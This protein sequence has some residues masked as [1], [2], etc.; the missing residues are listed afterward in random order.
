[1]EQL[2]KA[3]KRFSWF[4]LLSL[5][6]DA[7]GVVF[8]I[9]AAL[10]FPKITSGNEVP[11]YAM[12]GATIIIGIVLMI[13]TLVAFFSM[14]NGE[15]KSA[16]LALGKHTKIQLLAPLTC[17]VLGIVGILQPLTWSPRGEVDMGLLTTLIVAYVI[18]LFVS[19]FNSRGLKAFR[20]DKESYGYIST[21]SFIIVVALIVYCV[22]ATFSMTKIPAQ[23]ETHIIGYL[24]AFAILFTVGD[25]IAFLSLGIM[26]Q[27]VRKYAPKTTMADA[28]AAKLDELG[29]SIDKLSEKI[30]TDTPK[31]PAK[32]TS[33]PANDPTIELRKY[34]A[35]L[36]D[37]IITQE[38]FNKKKK[39]ILG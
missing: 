38:E 17:L 30:S 11:K 34:K 23:T 39:E 13:S 27:I 37:G 25:A 21:T 1:M 24:E 16:I 35:L 5:V 32:A 36:D 4:I 22:I 3:S 9:M 2:T 10:E 33:T 20:K 14:R 18:V 29:K 6:V 8:G 12:L 31:A 26:A 7:F 19:G 15:V 28:D